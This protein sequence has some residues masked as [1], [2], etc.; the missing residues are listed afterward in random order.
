MKYRFSNTTAPLLLAAFTAMAAPVAEPTL[1]NESLRY[2]V[3]WPT[4]V[5]L[6]EATLVASSS[7]GASG[8]PGHMHFVFDLDAGAPGFTISDR[9]RSEASGSFCSSEFEKSISHGSKKADDKETFDSESGTVTRGSGSGQSQLSANPCGKDALAFL[10]FLR[11]EL[12]Q[13]RM[14]PGQTVFF[15]A[16]YEVRLSLAGTESIKVGGAP[17]DADRISAEVSGPSSTISFEMLFLKDSSRT[18]ALVRVPL[19]LGKFSMELVK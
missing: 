2:S 7:P 6:G 19:A 3:N 16:P 10:Y 14:P 13:G 5:S 17:L 15:G 4:G 8:Q 1:P 18:L 12:R 11:Q 9:Y